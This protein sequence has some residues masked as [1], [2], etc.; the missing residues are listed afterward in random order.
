MAIKREMAKEVQSTGFQ[1]VIAD[2][3]Q[4]L[5]NWGFDWLKPSLIENILRPGTWMEAS[6]VAYI[7]ANTYAAPVI[8]ITPCL[9]SSHTYLPL[10]KGATNNAPLGLFF[11]DSNHF[12]FFK[13]GVP[14]AYPP[15]GYNWSHIRRESSVDW[16]G[17][18]KEKL[19][20]WEQLK[21]TW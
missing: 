17:K 9:A 20:L 13:M 6:G 3:R 11:V 1:K 4:Y 10:T 14:E 12:W 2:N 8:V 21:G 15:V 18:I 16:M 5:Q 7:A 19:D